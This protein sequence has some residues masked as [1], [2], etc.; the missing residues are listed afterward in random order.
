MK[1]MRDRAKSPEPEETKPY[2]ERRGLLVESVERIHTPKLES[3][4][5][6]GGRGGG[7]GEGRRKN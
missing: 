5:E 3:E 7:R 4:R 6:V 2:T 1:W